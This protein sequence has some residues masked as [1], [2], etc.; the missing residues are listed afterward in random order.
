[1]GRGISNWSSVRIDYS[2]CRDERVNT[3]NQVTGNECCNL[4]GWSI[5]NLARGSG[6]CND[7]QTCYLDI[8]KVARR[9]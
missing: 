9:T 6:V 3:G 8:M 7:G 5:S 2:I 1:M 4:F